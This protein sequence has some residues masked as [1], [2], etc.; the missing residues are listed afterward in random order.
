MYESIPDVFLSGVQEEKLNLQNAR[1]SSFITNTL[2]VCQLYFP[3]YKFINEAPL[4]LL[5]EKRH[6]S[7][8]KPY[9][10]NFGYDYKNWYIF[11]SSVMRNSEMAVELFVLH[12][13]RRG[14]STLIKVS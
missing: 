5:L 2:G 13:G 3:N 8:I 9:L 6:Y 11:F 7:Q 10:E 1:S 4:F 12:E 14:N